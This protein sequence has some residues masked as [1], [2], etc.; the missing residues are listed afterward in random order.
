MA[1]LEYLINIK[2]KIDKEDDSDQIISLLN[3]L[4]E[5]QSYKIN[6]DELIQSKLGKTLKKLS[7][8]SNKD[9]S[10]KALSV[11][12]ILKK[13]IKKSDQS[14]SNGQSSHSIP[15]KVNEDS[16]NDSIKQKEVEV[17][18]KLTSS[19]QIP[20][21]FHENLK[22]IQGKLQVE[23]PKRTNVRKLLLD[24]FVND[25]TMPLEQLGFI[26]NTVIEID[27]AIYNTLYSS[28]DNGSKYLQRAKT[29]VNN[30]MKGGEFKQRILNGELKIDEL[31]S[32]DVKEMASKDLKLKRLNVSE[33]GF[34][35]RRSDWNLI[36]ATPSIGLYSCEECKGERTS[37]FQLQIRG[38]DEPMTT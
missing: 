35:S 29:I 21:N 27:N 7:S 8:H 20:T 23:D 5:I 13:A 22:K 30:L 25:E 4:E 37:S 18:S 33:D 36:H 15:I 17:P 14:K 12:S 19:K 3:S 9:I 31:P 11:I 6:S 28:N 16:K 2:T 10:A 24:G 26:K 38:A 32:M 1:D 34:K